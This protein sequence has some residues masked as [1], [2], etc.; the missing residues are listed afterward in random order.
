LI[1]ITD[2]EFNEFSKSDTINK[3]HLNR[4]KKYLEKELSLF[5]F[6]IKEHNQLYF[7]F[8]DHFYIN[9]E[10][11]F[12]FLEKYL[13]RKKFVEYYLQDTNLGF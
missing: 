11:E 5:E 9:N 2:K 7:K 8:L 3:L 6:Y 13:Y 1:T 10:D 12:T 4:S